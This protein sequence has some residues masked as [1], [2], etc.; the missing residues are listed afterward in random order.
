VNLSTDLGRQPA[1]PFA[2]YYEDISGRITIQDVSSHE[3]NVN[4]TDNGSDDLQFGLTRSTYWIRFNIDWSSLALEDG[5]VLEV[6]PPKHVEGIAHCGTDVFVLDSNRHPVVSQ[7]LGS[8]DNPRERKTLTGGY[9]FNLNP[10]TDRQVYLRIETAR[11]LS[12]PITLW[13]QS[14]FRDSELI[15]N[16]AL[17]SCYGI[18]LAMNF[19]NLFLFFS[20]RESSFF[21]MY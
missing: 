12:V 17:G 3:F 16:V 21:I 20:I 7:R 13:Q 15:A 11:D 5:W 9:V 14:A 10:E 2:E 18:L 6:G 1:A 8:Y 4:L 19:Y